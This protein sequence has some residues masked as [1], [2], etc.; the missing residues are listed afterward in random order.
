M[1]TTFAEQGYWIFPGI[2]SPKEIEEMR[3][4]ARRLCGDNALCEPRFFQNILDTDTTAR[5]IVL[6]AKV[7]DALSQIL[8][9]ISSL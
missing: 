1:P 9:T 5:R 4:F 7:R 3:A 6:S 2:F 8:G